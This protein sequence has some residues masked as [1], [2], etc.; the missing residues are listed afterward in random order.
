MQRE[1]IVSMLELLSWSWEYE[2]NDLSTVCTLDYAI[3]RDGMFFCAGKN[4]WVLQRCN[5][6]DFKKKCYFF[7]DLD[8]RLDHYKKT[9][10]VLS[11]I[12][13]LAKINEIIG[14]LQINW[15]WDYRYAVFTGNGLHLYY[16][17]DEQEIDKKTYSD[18]V[19]YFNELVDFYIGDIT[20]TDPACSNIAR[21]SRLPWSYNPR[22]KMSWGNV[23]RD[24]WRIECEILFEQDTQSEHFANLKEYAILYQ[25]QQ[26]KEKENVSMVYS[27][28]KEYKTDD[29][30]FE[31]INAVP[32]WEIA[33]LVRWVTMWEFNNWI[34]PLREERKNMWA[35]VY[36]PYNVVVNTWSSLIKNKGTRSFTPRRLILREWCNWDTKEAFK[37]FSERYGIEPKKETKWIIP[38][39]KEYD[40]LW[41]YY[42][43]AA[44]DDFECLL[45][46][47]LCTIVANS[48]SWKTT[49]AM[50]MI[51][52]NAEQWK[53]WFYINLEFDIKNVPKQRRLMANGKTKRNLSDIAPLTDYEKQKLDTY[54]EEYLS[55]FAYYN[56]PNW[57]DLPT[58]V[59]IIKTKYDEWYSLFVIDSFLR[60]WGNWQ[61]EKAN[62]SQNKAMVTLQTLC[63]NMGAVIILLHHTNKKWEFSWSKD[64]LNLSNVFL[65]LEKMESVWG[66]AFTK[67]I[68][69]KDKFVN[70]KEL[71]VKWTEQWYFLCW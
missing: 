4:R 58:L 36:Q 7:V 35:Y 47:E 61:G 56:N 30:V 6:D 22:R 1:Q 18:G 43:W 12:D 50:G 42:P 65:S 41:Y 28:V 49:F 68:L 13:L 5:D 31:D 10:E 39:R 25:E 59:E 20:K 37:F 27:I 71:I 69:T 34:A 52:K 70:S 62:A 23:L 53:K 46:W 19:R 54:V 14:I 15:L 63:Q 40:L 9:W 57:E 32:V 55:K 16:V 29:K 45:S 21:L 11:H 67:F 8:I 2:I 44:F 3:G 64:I 51:Q 26:K 24:M 17:W 60:I 38:P 33:Q 66:D 48:N